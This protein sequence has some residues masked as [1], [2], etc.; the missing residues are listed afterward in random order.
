MRA[1]Y[2]LIA[3][4]VAILA[5]A[6][7]LPD[8]PPVY[9]CPSDVPP[10]PPPPPT[11]TPW[12]IPYI[13][14]TATPFGVPF[15]PSP[16]PPPTAVPTAYIITPP[17]DFY[18][19]D[20]VFV[21]QAGA[22]HRVRF[23]LQNV[24]SSAAPDGGTLHLW[25]LEVRNLGEQPY[26]ITPTLVMTLTALRLADGT[27][28]DG[29]WVATSRAARAAGIPVNEAVFELSTGQTMVFHFAALSASAGATAWRWRLALDYG[30]TSENAIGWR[31]AINPHCSGDVAD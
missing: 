6:T 21:G 23:R 16:L 30:G 8:A 13:P 15:I 26:T 3:L 9:V 4:C 1:I 2:A 5:C 24:A 27:I 7:P 10:P 22:G 12:G 29:N 14:P 20:A 11:V 25:Q 28:Q 31:N 17:D 18:V 19:G